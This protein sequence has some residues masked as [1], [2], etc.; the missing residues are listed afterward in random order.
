MGY[1]DPGFLKSKI[2][3]LEKD[4]KELRSRAVPFLAHQKGPTPG[5][6]NAAQVGPGTSQKSAMHLNLDGNQVG[7]APRL[8][9]ADAAG[10]VRVE[11]GNLAAQGN[12]PAQFGIRAADASGA[13]LF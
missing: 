12:S 9:V 7:S 8:S 6:I 3:K 4:L 1:E 5:W 11:L 2:E 13:V 10:T